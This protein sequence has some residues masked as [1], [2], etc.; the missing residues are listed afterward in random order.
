MKQSAAFLNESTSLYDTLRG[1]DYKVM[2]TKTKFKD[3]SFNDLIWI[4]ATIKTQRHGKQ[5]RHWRAVTWWAYKDLI[6]IIA[7]ARNWYARLKSGDYQSINNI[8]DLE[9]MDKGDVS[10][11]LPLTF[12]APSIVSAIIRGEHPID[13]TADTLR[14]KTAHLPLDWSEQRQF[15]GFDV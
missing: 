14:R 2:N 12:L 13:M 11:T 1:F 15:L 8:A 4:P 6:R 10:R 9:K 7:K 3:W 5:A